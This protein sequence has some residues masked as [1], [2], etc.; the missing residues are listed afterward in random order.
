MQAEPVTYTRWAVQWRQRNRLYGDLRELIWHNGEVKRFATR[1]EAR[2]WI[3]QN[4]GYIRNRPDLRREPHGW[5][6]PRP[7]RVRV[8]IEE[9]QR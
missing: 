5:Q 9:V 4:Y 7:V 6:M 2:V 8:T 1:A 3:E